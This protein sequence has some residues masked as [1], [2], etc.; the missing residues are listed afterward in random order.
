M[1]KKTSIDRFNQIYQM[2]K[3]QNIVEDFNSEKTAKAEFHKMI[4]MDD[5]I[6]HCPGYTVFIT[7]RKGSDYYKKEDVD[8]YWNKTFEKH[9]ISVETG[10]PMWYEIIDSGMMGKR[11]FKDCVSVEDV[12]MYG[13]QETR[14]PHYGYRH[15]RDENVYG[16]YVANCVNKTNTTK[17]RTIGDYGMIAKQLQ[18]KLGLCNIDYVPIKTFRVNSSEYEIRSKISMA[19]EILNSPLQPCTDKQA[20]WI[21]RKLKTDEITA[22]KLNKYQAS[23]LLDILFNWDDNQWA[24]D[25]DKTVAYYKKLLGLTESINRKNVINRVVK[26]VIKEEVRQIIYRKKV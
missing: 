7:F 13:E 18:E 20:L 17:Q 23:E 6:N 9:G 19:E 24:V 26:N 15:G 21:A 1:A 25:P 3:G 16:K 4:E 2:S 5:D 14:K 11:I 10:L 12:R 22:K 8:Y